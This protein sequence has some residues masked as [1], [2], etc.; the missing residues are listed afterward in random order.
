MRAATYTHHEVRQAAET[1]AVE[2]TR[3]KF[4]EL[5]DRHSSE[6]DARREQVLHIS[7]SSS[8]IRYLLTTIER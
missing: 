5:L 4:R 1:F 3:M 6:R 2:H 8:S 7:L